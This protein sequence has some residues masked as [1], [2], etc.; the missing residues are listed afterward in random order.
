MLLNVIEC[1]VIGWNVIQC[2]VI[3]WLNEI[4]L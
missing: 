3:E 4:E 2:N 1:S